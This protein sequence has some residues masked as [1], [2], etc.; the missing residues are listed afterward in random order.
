MYL[1]INLGHHDTS[2]CLLTE[3]E[4]NTASM[5]VLEEERLQKKK[6]AGF[7]PYLS[8]D[9]VQRTFDLSKLPA[10]QVAY[11]TFFL[12]MDETWKKIA[13]IKNKFSE[14]FTL[15]ESLSEK[16]HCASNILHH[17]AHLFSC[18]I[19]LDPKQDHLIVIS[20]GCGSQYTEVK[21]FSIFPFD[22]SGEGSTYETISVYSYR[23][24]KI[25]VLDKF[26][27]P[28]M[29]LKGKKEDFS[30]ASYFTAASQVVFGDWSY[31]GKV[32]GLSG[33]YDDAP[34]QDTELYQL[35][36]TTSFNTLSSKDYFD[37]LDKSMFDALAKICYS[38]QIYFENYMMAFFQKLKEKH[39]GLENLVY[40]GGTSLNC[41][42]N[43]KLRRKNLFKTITIP[44]W[45]NDE[46]VGM[47]AA[48]GSYYLKNK[49]LPTI[50]DAHSPFLGFPYAYSEA[51]V[52]KAFSSFVIEDLSFTRIAELIANNQIVA[53]YEGRSECGPRAL[54]HRSIFCSPFRPGIRDYLNDRIK[55]RER[56]RPYGCSVLQEQQ[57]EY[58]EQAEGLYSPYMSFAP[59]VKSEKRELLSEIL[60]VDNTI[61]I[62]TVDDTFP[63]LKSLLIELRKQTGHS[64][65]IHTSLNIN[66]QPILETLS[67]AVLFFK[68]SEIKYLVFDNLLIRKS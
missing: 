25:Q 41:I 18:L 21:K 3:S 29:L 9:I 54:G 4:D 35:L 11:S 64:L 53:W 63:N 61:R 20:D 37:D 65:V 62:Q 17:E 56:F 58:F 16:K 51:E 43:E 14:S 39:P 45:T 49:K 10:E 46:G 67:D 60:H 26:L 31:S 38:T 33:Y 55:M 13:S 57:E 48:I 7:Y 27:T 52:K 24:G 47:G 19:N 68:N 36:T 34:F 42:F 40:A 28:F 23:S 66:K 44:A 59:V 6:H 15:N 2:A 8:I 22:L 12:S 32:M 5:I 30:P 1:G 50:K